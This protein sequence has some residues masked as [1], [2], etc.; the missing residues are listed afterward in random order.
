M[1]LSGK[2]RDRSVGDLMMELIEATRIC[3]SSSQVRALHF[4]VIIVSQ[5]PPSLTL[6]CPFLH[7]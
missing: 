2:E 6:H 1:F 3:S 7:P 5:K 4:E